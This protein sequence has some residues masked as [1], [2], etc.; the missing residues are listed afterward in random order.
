MSN[1]PQILLATGGTAGHIFP[2]VA[3][4][5]ALEA[6]GLHS[7]VIGGLGGMEE[8]IA[9]RENLGFYGVRTGKIDRSRPDPRALFRALAGFWDAAA[10]VGKL[11][12]KAVVGFGGFASFPGVA[13]AWLR[14][15]PI[16]LHEG[17][18]RPGLVTKVFARSAKMIG[19]VD[20]A[21]KLELVGARTKLVGMP[22]REQRMTRLE[23]LEKLGL[24]PN[25][26]TIFI[27]GGSQGSVRLNKL[28][29][30]IL[31]RVLAGKNVQVLHQTGRGRLGEVKTSNWYHT[32]E[33]VDAIAAFGAADFAIT[34]A[35]FST[36]AEAAFHGVPLLLV[37]LPSASEDHQTKNA[38]GVEA[39]GAGF[40]IP[41]SALELESLSPTDSPGLLEKGILAC[42]DASKLEELRK[43]AFSASSAGAAERLAALVLEVLELNRGRT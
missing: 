7:A 26:Q 41:E 36:I 33:F 4:A 35:G 29:P 6:H 14:G 32:T 31:E 5:R 42:L 19:L 37:P 43:N 22:V 25:K 18:A 8:G 38:Q 23:A 13:G 30:P 9:T 28:L 11:R 27:M 21:A 40:L 24:E 20:E 1:S 39:R 16:V 12:P 2:A 17:N 3:L 10:T 15:V 34:R